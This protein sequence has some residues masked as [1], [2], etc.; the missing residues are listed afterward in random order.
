MH[1]D[2]ARSKRSHSASSSDGEEE[3]GFVARAGAVPYFEKAVVHPNRTTHDLHPCM[4][5]GS[6]VVAHLG[7][8]VEHAGEHRDVLVNC[9]CPVSSIRSRDQAQ[10][11]PAVGE[12]AL[13]VARSQ[14][15]LRGLDPDLKQVQWFEVGVVGFAVND[16]RARRHALEL[17][18]RDHRVVSH[19]VLMLEPTGDHVSEDLHVA[20][21]MTRESAA[22]GDAI[23]VQHS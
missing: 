8:G 7:A 6:E 13:L 5:S 9:Q 16:P 22:S 1:V 4:A 20:M 23:L 15:A 3:S 14:V 18:G 19:R 11:V 10:D 12:A 21:R 2:Q 17:T